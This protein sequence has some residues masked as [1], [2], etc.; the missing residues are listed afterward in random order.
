MCRIVYI[1]EGLIMKNGLIA[2]LKATQKFFN[3]TIECLNE[4]DS[5]F[6]PTSEL[7]TVAAHI[8]HTAASIEWFLEGAFGKGWDMDFETHIAECKKETSLKK[9]KAHFDKAINQAISVIE[10]A[11]DAELMEPIPDK[12]IMEGAPRL[13]IVSGIVDHTA[14]HRGALAVYARLIGKE[15][16]MPYA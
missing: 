12:R 6:T 9:A 4:K 14:H 2:E 13:S 10:T 3:K 16:S 7:Y 11:T 15:P 1:K 8:E 5:T